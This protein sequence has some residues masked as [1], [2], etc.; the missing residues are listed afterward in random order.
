MVVSA[1]AGALKPKQEKIEG[2]KKA[3][4]ITIN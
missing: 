1:G 3:G 2:K 4:V